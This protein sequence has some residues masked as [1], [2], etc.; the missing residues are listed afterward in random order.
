MPADHPRRIGPYEVLGPLG[1]GAVGQLY[2]AVE[3]SRN[4]LVAI[5]VL[6]DEFLEDETRLERFEQEAKAVAQLDHRNV[7]QVIDSDR[8]EDL[9]YLVME[10]V[11]GSPLGT[12]M[13]QRRLTLHEIFRVT[14]G[15]CAGLQAAHRQNIVHRD[16]N[17]RNVLVSEDLSVVKLVDFGISRLEAASLEQGTMATS[18]VSLRSL[19]YMSPEQ[20]TDPAEVDHRTDIYSLGVTLYEMLTGRVPVGRFSLPSQLNNEVPPDLDPLVLKCLEADPGARYPTVGQLLADLNRLEDRLKLGLVHELKGLSQQTS[21]IL[22]GSTGTFRGRKPLVIIAVAALVLVVGGAAAFLLF[23]SRAPAPG[24]E[25]L[26]ATAQ[27]ATT[28]P[29]APATSIE[30]PESA[31]GA[32]PDAQTEQPSEAGAATSADRQ[33]A[34]AAETAPAAEATPEPAPVAAVPARAA[35]DLEVARD[36]IAAGLNSPALADLERFVE[37]HAASPL[38]PEAYLLMAHAHRAEGRTE[39]ALATYVEIGSRYAGS[40]QAPAAAFERARLVGEGAG[41][42]AAQQARL[43]FAEVA[44]SHPDSKWA[45]AALAAQ[46]KIENDLKMT[47]TDPA[48]ELRAPAAIGPCRSLVERYPDTPEAEWA[49]W[50]LG[51]IYSDLKKFELAAQSFADLGRRFP[52]TDYDAW[53]RAGQIFDRRLSQTDQAIEAYR[54]VP[55]SSNHH[56]DA[57]RRIARLSR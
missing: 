1:K 7:V 26:A 31:S 9:L 19:H 13:R 41:K 3:P 25:P 35:E 23:G 17:P 2:K 56:A 27:E 34:A 39:E 44:A 24:P 38:V 51:E 22:L 21:K 57:Q 10:Y 11:P 16:L 52:G 50:Q 45:P 4:R 28:G 46:A 37:E 36:K 8:E 20:A 55:D 14:K 47:A 33:T 43:L 15:I 30:Q 32:E 42:E 12:V 6:P 54:Q 48:L 49:F 5:K 53:W 29:I 18:E 40:P